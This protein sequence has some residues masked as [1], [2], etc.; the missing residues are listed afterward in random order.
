MKVDKKQV[1]QTVNVYIADDGKE[2][3]FIRDFE[4]EEYKRAKTEDYNRY[5]YVESFKAKVKK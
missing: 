1:M 5:G 3:L 2:L 4:V